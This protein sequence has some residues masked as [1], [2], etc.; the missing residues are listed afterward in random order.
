MN[1]LLVTFQI[2]MFSSSGIT[3]KKCIERLTYLIR[4]IFS[5]ELTLAFLRACPMWLSSTVSYAWNTQN[6][7]LALRF[8]ELEITLLGIKIPPTHPRIT[9]AITF[10]S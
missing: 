6:G 7:D 9:V 10:E 3:Q 2:D 5:P 4:Q 8:T 1:K